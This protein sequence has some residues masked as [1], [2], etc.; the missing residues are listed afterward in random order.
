VEAVLVSPYVRQL[1]GVLRICPDALDAR[2]DT[3]QPGL[4]PVI[5]GERGGVIAGERG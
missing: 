5:Q 3:E 1:P 2:Q 4:W